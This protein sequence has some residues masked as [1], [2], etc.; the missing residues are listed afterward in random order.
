MIGALSNSLGSSGGFVCGDKEICEHQRLSGQA[1]TFSA[2]LPAMLA[3]AAIS[4][5]AVM[6]E[7]P[8][9]L[10]RLCENTVLFHKTLA[11]KNLAGIIE[12]TGGDFGEEGGVVPIVFI[13]LKHRN[14]EAVLQ[15]I[16]DVALKDGLIVTRAKSCRGQE[17]DSIEPCIRVALSG[18]LS[19]REVEKA[20]GVLRDSI[21][22]VVKR[23]KV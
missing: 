9:L 5:L 16:C 8:V 23:L 4:A 17:R 15:D 3:V 10:E 2:S 1:Y 20:A 19:K 22:S 14:E 21:K 18:G 13:R 11:N 7:E 6:E 12:I